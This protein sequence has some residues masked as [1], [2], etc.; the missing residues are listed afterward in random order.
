MQL[1]EEI[2]NKTGG[3]QHH[4]LKIAIL[5]DQSSPQVTVQLVNQVIARNEPVLLGPAFAATCLAAAP[6]VAKTGPVSFCYSPAIRPARGGFMFSAGVNSEDQL[7]AYMYFDN[8]TPQTTS[9]V[10][11]ALYCVSS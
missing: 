4:P 11:M 8:A 2:V 1:I 7:R 3:I 6:L 9:R 10:Q 5:D